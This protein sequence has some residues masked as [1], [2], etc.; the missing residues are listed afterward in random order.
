MDKELSSV[1]HRIR[2]AR[3]E[4]EFSQLNMA[5]SLGISQEHYSRMENG[6]RK[7]GVKRLMTICELLEIEPRELFDSVPPLGD[8]L[9][10]IDDS[11]FVRV[12]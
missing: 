8:G 3:N 6:S 7:L 2:I 10:E 1:L 11:C 4:K 12:P 9:T 5:D